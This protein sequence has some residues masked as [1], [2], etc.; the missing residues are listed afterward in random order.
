MKEITGELWDYY[1][2]E[3]FVVCITTNGTVKKNGE[4]VM[5]RGCA[6]EATERLPRIAKRLG[7]SLNTIGLQFFEPV[8]LGNEWTDPIAL[9]P[10]KYNWWEQADLELIKKS[11][12]QLRDRALAWP[13]CTYILPRPGCGNGRLTWDQVKPVIDFLPD[14]VWVISKE[15]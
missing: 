1:G 4:A 6:K 7:A 9:F 8:N 15:H 5:G 14:N 10:V 13:N 12:S 11:A 2:K 3:N